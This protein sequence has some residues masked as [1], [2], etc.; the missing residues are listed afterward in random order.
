MLITDRVFLHYY[1]TLVPGDMVIFASGIMLTVGVIVDI[2]DSPESD[3]MALISEITSEALQEIKSSTDFTL[4]LSQDLS[5]ADYD[6]HRLPVTSLYPVDI[7][8]GQLQEYIQL[9]S[10]LDSTLADIY[11]KRNEFLS[12][13]IKR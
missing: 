10:E 9:V 3:A 12:K 1:G 5:L 8:S 4:F 2:A 13:L 11:I 6:M 7:D